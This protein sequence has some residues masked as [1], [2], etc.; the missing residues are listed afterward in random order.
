MAGTRLLLQISF[1]VELVVWVCITAYV[2]LSND[3]L[4]RKLGFVHD[5]RG[6]LHDID[7]HNKTVSEVEPVTV[8]CADSQVVFWNSFM[9][10]TDADKIR[11]VADT[12]GL[13]QQVCEDL[14]TAIAAAFSKYDV[15]ICESVP[16][17]TAT[18]MVIHN[19][20]MIWYA[21]GLS[22]RQADWNQIY[23]V[24]PNNKMRHVLTIRL[25]YTKQDP[26]WMRRTRDIIDYLKGNRLEEYPCWKTRPTIEVME[27]E[28]DLLP[29]NASESVYHIRTDD[30]MIQ[31]NHDDFVLTVVLSNHA[32]T[33][34]AND[35]GQSATSFVRGKHTFAIVQ[36]DTNISLLETT[37]AQSLDYLIATCMN[38][39]PDFGSGS[40]VT[41]GSFP[42]LYSK[43]WHQRFVYKM[44]APLTRA[45]AR[46]KQTILNLPRSVHVDKDVVST[47]NQAAALLSRLD[48]MDAVQ[49]AFELLAS[50]RS[51]ASLT[52]PLDFPPE[53]YAAIFSPLLLPLFLPLLAGVRRE[54][55]RYRG[56]LLNKVL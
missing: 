51:H 24:E 29:T 40:I 18:R 8:L 14:V 39:P 52:H 42:L 3:L 25:L 1:L 38:V 43:I 55:R 36:P 4:A 34:F 49:R 16:A 37:L 5:K 35:Q 11:V 46:E 21:R 44:R 12:S 54:Y 20:T 32:S 50:V 13:L 31:T 30:K 23:P 56:K 45:L 10:P 6:L 27:A 28:T 33:V 41:D 19:G 17:P 26:L 2:G 7:F 53:Q 48:S 9:R 47:W 22:Q 15:Y